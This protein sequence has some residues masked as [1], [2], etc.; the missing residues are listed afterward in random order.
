MKG[1]LKINGFEVDPKDERFILKVPDRGFSPEHNK[2]VVDESI[3]KYEEFR[4]KQWKIWED[5]TRERANALAS[6]F[7]YLDTGKGGTNPL[8]KYFSRKTRAYLRGEKIIQEL[9][10]GNGYKT[11]NNLGQ[12]VT[13]HNAA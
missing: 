12:V 2:A 4:R 11:V 8:M 7:K 3:R 1:K 5:K 13:Y 9:R 6:Y 10:G